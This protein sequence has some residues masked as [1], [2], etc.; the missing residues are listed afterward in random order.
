MRVDNMLI[1]EGISERC[2]ST[3]LSLTKNFDQN[4]SFDFTDYQTKLNQIRQIYNSELEKYENHCNDFC[5][6]TETLLREQSQLRPIS[7]HE[8]ERM[9]KIIRKKFSII[10][11]QLKQS[12]CEAA[13]ILRSRSLDARKKR[14]NFSKL[15]IE[16][17]NEYFYSHLS[18]P[19]PSEAT[20]EE[21]AHQCGISVAQVCNW[22]GN[23][24]IRCKKNIH[25]TEEE[26]NIYATRL[27]SQAPRHNHDS[28]PNGIIHFNIFYS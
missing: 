3:N 17:L 2:S 1:A 28:F 22:F 8:I 9:I 20:K 15:A 14:R 6:H 13:M 10:Q 26:A 27:A 19:Y 11:L 25:K 23:K 16:T 7:E 18:N 4:N 5:L 21:L 24:R 12:T